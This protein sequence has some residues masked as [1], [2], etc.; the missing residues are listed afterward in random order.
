MAKTQDVQ[1][2]GIPTAGTWLID[3][4]HTNVG[5][6][7]RHLMV[8][9]VRGRFTEV[10]GAITIG[11]T[12]ETS[13]IDVRMVAASIDT[14]DQG[15]DDHLRS[16]DFL[17]VERFPELTF[18]SSNVEVTGDR[19]LRVT[20]DLTIRDVT[21]PVVLDVE[22]EGL[23]VDPWGNTKAGFSATTEIDREA[24]GITW[25][26]AL[27]AGGVLVGNRVKI[28]LEVQAALQATGEKTSAA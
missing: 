22:Y 15:R 11:E 23:I 6:V 2:S 16:P 9:K 4:A 19:T 18:R 27:E 28:E 10:E 1:D 20:G 7:A 8:T 3:Q 21:R 17:D 25:N 24:F 26:A 12:P 5:F 13:K 14:A